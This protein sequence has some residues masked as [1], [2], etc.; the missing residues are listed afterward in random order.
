MRLEE[1]SRE[2]V[3]TKRV[4]ERS[5]RIDAKWSEMRKKLIENL[6]T[7]QIIKKIRDLSTLKNRKKY[8]HKIQN[9]AKILELQA[10][11]I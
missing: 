8:S 1:I 5:K 3:L 6:L 2:E 11:L 7:S 4:Q 10:D 9:C